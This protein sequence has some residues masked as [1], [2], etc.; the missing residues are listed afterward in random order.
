MFARGAK[1][2]LIADGTRGTLSDLGARDADAA[3]CELVQVGRVAFG[4]ELN[5]ASWCEAVRCGV[6]TFDDR[7]AIL[8]YLPSR[9][10]GAVLNDAKRASFG[11]CAVSKRALILIEV[12]EV[13][14][15]YVMMRADFQSNFST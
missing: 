6:V 15:R 12:A 2:L 10:T 14:T 8:R 7:A 1:R 4:R 13:D 3:E 11:R 5:G 9:R